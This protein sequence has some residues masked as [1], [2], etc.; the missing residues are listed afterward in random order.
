MGEVDRTFNEGDGEATILITKSGVL[1]QDL[2]IS[3]MA[4]SFAEFSALNLPLSD[5]FNEMNFPD[6]AE[7]K[8][9]MTE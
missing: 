3:L 6:P 9:F 1:P 5:E 4:Y 7:C 2:E 8:I